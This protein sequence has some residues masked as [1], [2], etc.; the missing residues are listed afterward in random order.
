[1]SPTHLIKYKEKSIFILFA[2]DKAHNHREKGVNIYSYSTWIAT[3]L[4]LP[5]K[6]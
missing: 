1:L 3:F 2:K 4:Q 5:S 6:F